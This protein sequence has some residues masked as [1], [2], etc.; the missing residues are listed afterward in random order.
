[1]AVAESLR[2]ELERCGLHLRSPPPCSAHPF[3]GRNG[4]GPRLSGCTWCSL[5]FQVFHQAAFMTSGLP[6]RLAGGRASAQQL[7]RMKALRAPLNERGLH[8]FP[9]S[10]LQCFNSVQAP[11]ERFEASFLIRFSSSSSSAPP[12]QPA[13][14]CVLCWR[15]TFAH[16]HSPL[17]FLFRRSTCQ[18][19]N[20]FPHLALS[21]IH[22]FQSWKQ[23]L[24]LPCSLSVMCAAF[25]GRC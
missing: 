23:R 14:L 4:L 25:G 9:H 2:M 13:V 8:S 10:L 5:P 11:R 1:M 22:L 18:S 17:P 21:K 15:R 24:R 3:V 6:V 7:H 16:F 20:F 12:P 19:I